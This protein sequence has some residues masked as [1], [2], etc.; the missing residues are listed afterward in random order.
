MQLLSDFSKIPPKEITS[1]FTKKSGSS[2]LFE[3]SSSGSPLF[4]EEKPESSTGQGLDAIKERLDKIATILTDIGTETPN[5]EGWKTLYTDSMQ[6][7]L[8]RSFGNG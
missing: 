8:E 4:K 3:D 1:I 7:A 6:A 2:G 5:K